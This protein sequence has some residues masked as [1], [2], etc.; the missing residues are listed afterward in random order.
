M[1]DPV[2]TPPEP[3]GGIINSDLQVRYN[4]RLMNAEIAAIIQRM[5]EKLISFTATNKGREGSDLRTRV[6][7]LNAHVAASVKDSTL[8]DRMLACFNAAVEAGITVTQLDPVL[9]QLR[10]EDPE[11]LGALWTAQSG[12]FYALSS[13]CKIIA[14][15]TFES[16]DDIEAMQDRMKTSFDLA[17]DMAADDADNL[18]YQDLVNLAATLARFL[19]QTSMPLPSILWYY[20]S[21]MPAL[22]TSYRIYSDASRYD[23]IVADNK[24]VHPAFC[25]GTIRALSKASI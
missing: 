20:L 17:K 16:R 22:A 24:I 4:V 5:T 10:S 18:V 13:Q 2:L 3:P 1:T 8:P 21:P 15:T 6:G 23:E 19:A 12:I 7:D 25:R 9:D 14:V 11:T